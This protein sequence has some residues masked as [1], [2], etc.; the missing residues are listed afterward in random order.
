MIIFVEDMYVG[1]FARI[2]GAA[3]AFRV[4]ANHRSFLYPNFLSYAG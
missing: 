2:S 1:R 3:V 4:A